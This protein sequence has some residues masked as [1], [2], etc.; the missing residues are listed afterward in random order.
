MVY[1]V[2]PPANQTVPFLE[3]LWELFWVSQLLEFS[4]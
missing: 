4:W 3:Q 1:T 2:I